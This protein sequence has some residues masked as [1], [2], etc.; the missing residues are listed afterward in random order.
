VDLTQLREDG[1][2]EDDEARLS[3]ETASGG[4]AQPGDELRH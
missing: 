3:A 1:S 2:E 4:G